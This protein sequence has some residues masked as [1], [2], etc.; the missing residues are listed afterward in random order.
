MVLQ[1]VTRMMIRSPKAKGSWDSHF[2]DLGEMAFGAKSRKI[3]FHLLLEG[4]KLSL[5][6]L[7][8]LHCI[9]QCFKIIEKVSFNIARE[10]ASCVHIL[11]AQNFIKNAKNGQFG[12]VFEK[13][14]ILG[15][16]QPMCNILI[17][18]LHLH[19]IGKWG[20]IFGGKEASMMLQR[21]SR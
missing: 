7:K 21:S 10:E 17:A 14:D 15:D 13:W 8:H 6:S 18:L 19:Y 11:S 3:R 2:P 1:I 12:R 4:W 9:A 16:F 20:A 5:A